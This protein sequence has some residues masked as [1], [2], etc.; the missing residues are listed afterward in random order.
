MSVVVRSEARNASELLPS[1]RAQ[2]K[3]F[4]PNQIIWRTQT[5]EELLGKSVAPRRF[6]MMLLGIFAAV[7]LVLAA[8]GLYGVMSY[9]VS[10]RI[11]EIG[12]RMALGADRSHVLR[13]VVRQGMTLTLIGLV[14]GLAGAF[15]LSRVLR[16]LLFEVSPSD[17]LT[18]AGVSF[19]LL[20]VALLACL[21]PARRA[22]RVD[23]IV[24]LRTE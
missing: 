11:H 4:D 1:L 12:I 19:V 2:V 21:V 6:N 8:V 9:S 23:P 16:S 20:I 5:F 14:L 10:W 22:T 17:P 24:A 13:L 3:A 7:A 15:G 18:F